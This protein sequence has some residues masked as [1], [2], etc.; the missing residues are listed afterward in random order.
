M[1]PIRTIAA[2]LLLLTF[3]AGC[4]DSYDKVAANLLA[5]V[6][7]VRDTL[8]SVKDPASANLAAE[9]IKSLGVEMQQIRAR[10]NKLGK[11]SKD[12]GDQLN[13]KYQAQIRQVED[14]IHAEHARIEAL[15]PA[16]LTP[17]DA[18]MHGG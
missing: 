18:A 5:N 1:K 15:G 7:T 3:V 4:G 11:P 10:M 16:V 13:G 14:Q 6:Q 17:V 8:K 2:A 9:K 12:V